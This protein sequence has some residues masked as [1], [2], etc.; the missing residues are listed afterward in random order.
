M[1]LDIRSSFPSPGPLE[2][3]SL[4]LFESSFHGHE[5]DV[6]DLLN[7]RLVY[8]DVCDCQGLTSL[9][10]ATYNAHLNIINLLLDFGGNVNQ[11][12]DD[13]LT[14]LGLAFLLYYGNNLY[15]TVNIAFEHSDPIILNPRPPTVFEAN[16]FISS[17]P[18]LFTSSSYF[19]TDTSI[20]EEMRLPSAFDSLKMN[21]HDQ[22]SIFIGFLVDYFHWIFN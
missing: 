11:L 3:A 4:R 15:Q 9:H 21:D 19:T 2:N 18:N 5:K 13:G 8:V 17:K 1:C 16:S 6:R 14:P 20:H 12:S 7:Q 10:F 22:K